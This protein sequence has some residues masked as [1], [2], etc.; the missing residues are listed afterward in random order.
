MSHINRLVELEIG[1]LDASWIE[2]RIE[3]VDMEELVVINDEESAIVVLDI[4]DVIEWCREDLEDL[5]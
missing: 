4:K 2:I 1:L 3:I 5:S